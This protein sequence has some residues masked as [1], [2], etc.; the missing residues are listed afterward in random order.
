[1]LTQFRQF[2][3]GSLGNWEIG[4]ARLDLRKNYSPY[5]GRAYPIP[6]LHL[7]VFKQEVD[8]LEELGV[9]KRE[10]DFPWG[11]PTFIMP[12]KQGTICFL[13]DFRE[14]NKRLVRKS[15]PLPKN[16]YSSARTGWL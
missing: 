13:I 10:K 9:L 4:P 3:D 15:W 12:K 8:R 16:Q 6:K 7:D 5:C 11:S 2:F 1:M 14:V